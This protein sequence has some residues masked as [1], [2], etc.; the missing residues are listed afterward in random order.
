MKSFIGLLLFLSIS[1]AWV[2]EYRAPDTDNNLFRSVV[3]LPSGNLVWVDNTQ[4]D[5]GM[6]IWNGYSLLCASSCG[7]TLWT[8]SF[9]S[10]ECWN[11][12]VVATNDG[13]I[14]VAGNMNTEPFWTGDVEYLYHRVS[15]SGDSLWLNF[16]D[17]GY[18][19]CLLGACHGNGDSVYLAGYT[20]DR[21]TTYT[22]YPTFPLVVCISEDGAVY[23]SSTFD[24]EYERIRDIFSSPDGSLYLITE[25]VSMDTFIVNLWN[26]SGSGDLNWTTELYFSPAPISRFYIRGIAHRNGVF[27]A[28]SSIGGSFT[29][30]CDHSGG[31]VWWRWGCANVFYDVEQVD[32]STCVAL[33]YVGTSGSRDLALTWFRLDGDTIRTVVIP[34]IHDEWP[35]EVIRL[36]NGNLAIAAEGIPLTRANH[37]AIAIVVDSLGNDV[38]SKISDSPLLQPVRLSLHA[39]P[40]PFNSSVR[41]LLEDFRGVGASDARSGQVGDIK[42]Y[43]ITGQLVADLPV[44]STGGYGKGVESVEGP[45]PL[46]WEPDKNIESGIYLLRVSIGVESITGRV[47]FLK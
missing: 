39:Y 21:D 11:T 47:I 41:I 45:T 3:E 27:I 23:W 34:Y 33:G 25:N 13:D 6:P 9:N 46:I 1:F 24:A 20:Q 12:R 18:D 5:L 40:N 26:I 28:G 29:A 36:S 17:G 35:Y 7:D 19:D 44:P 22:L 31:S 2:I 10:N 37:I 42:I 15:G 43:D 4:L 14:L 38:P 8:R 32:D 16:Y 30:G